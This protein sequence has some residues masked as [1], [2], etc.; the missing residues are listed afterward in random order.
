MNPELQQC[1]STSRGRD[2]EVPDGDARDD[3]G[4]G[5]LVSQYPTNRVLFGT[6]EVGSSDQANT[7]RFSRPVRAALR[8][9]LAEASEKLRKGT[10][11][12]LFT[13]PG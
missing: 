12:R 3:A 8:E 1:T 13:R 5:D 11:E 4:C 6:D 9:A 7:S 10:I 2:G